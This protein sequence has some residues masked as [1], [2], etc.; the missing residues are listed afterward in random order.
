VTIERES[1]RIQM[2]EWKIITG[3]APRG[4]GG[5]AGL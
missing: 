3:A 4:N 5:F 2:N 1:I